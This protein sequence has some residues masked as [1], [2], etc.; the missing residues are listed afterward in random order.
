M[1]LLSGRFA[2]PLLL[3]AALV[4]VGFTSSMLSATG[5][6]AAPQVVDLLLVCQ[7]AKAMAEGHPFQYN[8]G[9]LP[10]TGATSLLHT[11]VLAAAHGLGFRGE[12]LVAFAI[13]WGA[14]LFVLSVLLARRVGE[15]LAGER[16]GVLAGALMVV[17]GPVVWG[18]L[19][20]SDTALFMFLALLLFDRI[21]AEW[22]MPAPRGVALAG[23]LLALA[24]PEGLPIALIVATAW[25]VAPGR[26]SLGRSR[27]WAWIPV[28]VGAGVLGLYRALTGAWLGSSLADKSLVANYGFADAL[29]LSTQYAVDVLR[30][31]LLGFYPSEAPVGFARGW[32]SLFFPPLG[33]LLVLLAFLRP[34]PQ[35]RVPLA[36][37][38]MA[39]VTV[40]VLVTPNMFMGVHFNR[41]LLW[42]MPSLLVLVAV[43]LGSGAR[44]LA[45][46]DH[47]AETRLF[48][49]AA[50]LFL[51]LGLLSTTRFGVLYGEMA[52]EVQGRDVAAASWISSHLPAGTRVANVATS[53]EYLTGHR[54]VNLHGVTS[55]SFF[56]TRSAEREAG[57]FEA[58]GDLPERERPEYLLTS[59]SA[60]EGYPTLRELVREPPLFRG[61][62]LG[63]DLLVFNM[64]YDLVGKNHRLYL[65]EARAAVEGLRE[66]DRLNVGDARDE[67]R[68]EYAF[69]S[70]LAGV[71]LW[72]TARIASY[73]VG[74]REERV[75]DAGRAILGEESFVVSA[76]PGKE[77]RMVLRTAP[78]IDATIR[79]ASGSRSIG[80]EFPEA[81][82]SVEIDG[83]RV[84]HAALRPR[85]GWDEAVFSIPGSALTTPKTRL[86][87]FGRYASFQYWF[88]Q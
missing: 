86:R 72:G 66:V 19:Y 69:R 56:G 11:A 79:R 53:V 21:V 55:P 41:Y 35:H 63:D 52:G 3:A 28:G 37:W 78:A 62:S 14:G 26:A 12:G 7:Y 2:R 23:G 46:A 24:R 34:K 59:V 4:S 87:V 74:G 61:S 43:G 8:A 10:S 18:F 9:E 39:L 30:G 67:A 31:L 1:G 57:S 70:E 64:R 27:L 49:L 29:A 40:S 38:A 32:S 16:E 73:A 54:N 47:G 58:L 22:S 48:N 44:L 13:A 6:H 45:F 75:I 15:Q 33:L 36:L 80:I 84:V 85:D 65:P 76:E 25:T 51:V 17:G 60:Q 83:T 88:F 50:G 81:D 20:G 42:A 68:H 71:P 77:M 82:V 5:G